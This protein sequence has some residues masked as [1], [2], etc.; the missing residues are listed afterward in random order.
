M[1]LI[2]SFYT[3]TFHLSVYILIPPHEICS[4]EIGPCSEASLHCGVITILFSF[5]GPPC[6]GLSLSL[7]SSPCTHPSFTPATPA[8]CSSVNTP[9]SLLPQGLFMCCSHCL[10]GSPGSFLA[11][12]LTPFSSLHECHLK[13]PFLTT[14][15]KTVT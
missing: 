11:H 10:E 5:P 15:S 2:N 3:L 9:T 4:E 8:F 6:P 7:T 13:Y 12:S 1:I 14:L